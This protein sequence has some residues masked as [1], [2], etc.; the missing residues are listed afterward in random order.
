M[1]LF[2]QRLELRDRFYEW[3]DKEKFSERTPEMFL[4]FLLMNDLVDKKKTIAFLEKKPKG[5]ETN[6]RVA[7]QT[8]AHCLEQS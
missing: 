2:S 3:A 8:E 1:L 7:G 4:V 6:E 5:A